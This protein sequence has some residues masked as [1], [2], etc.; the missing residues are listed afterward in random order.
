MAVQLVR[1]VGY[2]VETKDLM[3]VV[4]MVAW[5][6]GMLVV[7]LVDQLAQMLAGLWEMLDDL[8]VD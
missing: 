6:A 1:L 4:M 3:S 5:W 2:L 8:M 7:Y